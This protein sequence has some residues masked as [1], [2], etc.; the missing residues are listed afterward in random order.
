MSML[1]AIESSSAIAA[2]RTSTILYPIVNATH[3][4]GLGLLLGSILAADV[5]VLGLWKGAGWRRAVVDLSPVAGVGLLVAVLSGGVLFTV[6]ASHYIENPAL[7][8]KWLLIGIAM[9]NLVVFHNAL[10]RTDSAAPTPMLR[11]C[12][13]LSATCWIGAVFA[14]R[15]IAFIA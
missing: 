7:L 15:W 6:R 10:R 4:L 13:A 11:I 1:S 8:L 12:A 9:I 2:I 3:I 5:R 14:G